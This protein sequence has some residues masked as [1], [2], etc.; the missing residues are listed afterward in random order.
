DHAQAR[1]ELVVDPGERLAGVVLD[2]LALPAQAVVDRQVLRGLPAVLD[3]EPGRSRAAVG[4]DLVVPVL[5]L[6]V[7]VPPAAADADDLLLDPGAGEPARGPFE[8]HPGPPPVVEV[9]RVVGRLDLAAELH[10]VRRPE[11]LEGPAQEPA[12]GVR[13]AGVGVGPELEARLAEQL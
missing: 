12:R 8:R 7:P 10:V 9:L 1:R 5:A 4:L 11:T 2:L 3:E 13:P 6:A